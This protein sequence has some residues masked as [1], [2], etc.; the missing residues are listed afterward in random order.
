MIKL[1]RICSTIAVI[2]FT[3]SFIS[4]TLCKVIKH[5]GIYVE[6][7]TIHSKLKKKPPGKY[8]LLDCFFVLE[9]GRWCVCERFHSRIASSDN[10]YLSNITSQL[11]SGHIFL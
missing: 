10:E 6:I 8:K 11:L 5:L 2:Q 3:M 4:I 1:R 9:R 7:L